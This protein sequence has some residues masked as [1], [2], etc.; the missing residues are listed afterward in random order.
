MKEVLFTN[1]VNGESKSVMLGGLGGLVFGLT[2]SVYE[3]N[4]AI[5]WCNNHKKGDRFACDSYE[6]KIVNE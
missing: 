6:I 3:T 5:R 1:K 4:D 2:K